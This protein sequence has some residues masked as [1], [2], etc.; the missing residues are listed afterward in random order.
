MAKSDPPPAP[1][2]KGAAKET[3]ASSLE[4]TRLAADLNR[5]NIN[6]PTGTST[7]TQ[8]PGTFDQAGFDAAVS[9]ANTSGPKGMPGRQPDRKDFTTSG[10]YTQTIGLSPEQQRIFNTGQEAQQ[11]TA[12]IGR[13]LA[14][15]SADTLSSPFD[16]TKIGGGQQEIQ[17][18]LYRRSAAMLD[19]QFQQQE[20]SERDRLAQQGFQVGTEG[21][22]KAIG[23]FDRS[24]TA[25]Y[26][27]ARDRAIIGGQAAQQQAVAQAMA[28]RSGNVNELNALRTGS[29]VTMPSFGAA[30][31]VG[32]PPGTDFSGATN[33]AGQNSMANYGA[34]VGKDNATNQAAT[35][36]AMMGAMYM[37]F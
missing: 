16:P 15:S 19:P 12:E 17:D 33:A 7:W 8:S 32:A 10:K 20:S 30:P 14:T 5:P 26:G 25:A 28:A 13:N 6:T 24:K 29:Q 37:G 22:D 23:N 21:Y 1:D 11:K 34:Q 35:S 36:A 2:Y 27:D 3:G 31:P 4:N 18:A 9:K